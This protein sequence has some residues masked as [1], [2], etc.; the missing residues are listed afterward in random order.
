VIV[1]VY[2]AA[3]LVADA[4]SSALA[5]SA[6]P[7]DLVV[8][9]DGST[10]DVEEALEPF[11]EQIVLMRQENRG[12]SAAKNAA[13]RAARGE[14]VVVLDADDVFLP[15]RLEALAE[16]AVARPDLDI[17]TTDAYLELDGRVVRRCYERDFDFETADQRAAILRRNFIFGLAAIRRT[18]L[19]ECSGFDEAIR[20]TADWDLW[21][22]M[23]LSGSRAG[24]VAQPLARYR[25]QRASLS[26]Q[27]ATLIEGRLQT[28]AK[29]ARRDDLSRHERDGLERS[30]RENRRLLALA[31]ARE[32]VLEHRADARRLA[33]E[34]ARSREQPP[35]TRLKAGFSALAP[36]LARRA[37]ARRPIETTAGIRYRPR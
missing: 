26:A 9:D 14:F 5:Q 12:E 2:Q 32:A 4:V 29:A 33:L 28:L 24:C 15:D 8:C 20:H 7:L 10:D 27:R 25:L 34:V 22:R 13:A 21:V 19:L 18:R 36:R 6:P 30:I 3:A 23:I 17:L 11:R 1:A 37:L 16:L 31:A 35:L